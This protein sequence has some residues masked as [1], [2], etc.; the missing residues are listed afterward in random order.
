MGPKPLEEPVHPVA[1]ITEDRIDAPVDQSLHQHIGHSFL[2]CH[3]PSIIPNRPLF[4][5]A[6]VP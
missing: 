3:M 5:M 2:A 1:R 6:R 4:K